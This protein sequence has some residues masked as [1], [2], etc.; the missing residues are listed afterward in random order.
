[1]PADIQLSGMEVSLVNAMS[2]EN[3][4]TAIPGHTEGAILPY[5]HRLPALPGYAH[6]QRTGSRQQDY[7]S[8]SGRVSDDYRTYVEI[9]LT[10]GRRELTENDEREAD[11]L[12]KRY[13]E[14]WREE[15]E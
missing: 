3:D 9:E 11:T 6:G 4:F 14:R 15:L 10:K 12:C 2:R 1:M 5:P 7:N 8:R 13:L